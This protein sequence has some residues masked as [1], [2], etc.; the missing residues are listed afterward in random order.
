MSKLEKTDK[1][2]WKNWLIIWVVG[3]AGQLCWNV[4]N[5]W[6]NTFVYEKIAPN[7]D[8]I[9]WMVAVSATVTTLSLLLWAR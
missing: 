7:P 3:L 2:G 1:L 4:E 8:I 6:F 9:K 5:Q